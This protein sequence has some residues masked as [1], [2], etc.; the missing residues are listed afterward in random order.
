MIDS[1]VEIMWKIFFK[2]VDKM[3]LGDIEESFGYVVYFFM[4]LYMVSDYYVIYYCGVLYGEW[5]Y[6]FV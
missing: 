4:G 3:L 2:Y 1:G 5:V 6:Y